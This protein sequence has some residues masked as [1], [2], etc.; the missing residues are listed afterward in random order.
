MTWTK[1]LEARGSSPQ[2]RGIV[3]MIQ[4][5]SGIAWWLVK[6]MPVWWENV[7]DCRG[8]MTGH[9]GRSSMSWRRCLIGFKDGL[10]VGCGWG[11]GEPGREIGG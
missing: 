1:Y 3:L 9:V 2:S 6:M 5:M 4:L 8:G 11:V 10:N 7:W